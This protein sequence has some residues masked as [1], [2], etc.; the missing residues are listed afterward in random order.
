MTTL[1]LY[2][3]QNPD[4]P[5]RTLRLR[6]AADFTGDPVENFTQAEEIHGKPYFPSHPH[7]HFSVSHTGKL[8]ICAFSSA[9]VG[10]DVQEYL[11]NDTTERWKRLAKRWFSEGERHYLDEHDCEPAEF[12]RIWARK[13]AYVKFTGDGIGEGNFP[14]FDVTQPIPGCVMQDIVLPYPENHAAALVCAEEFVP[15]LR[16]LP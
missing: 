9:A 7:V 13:E 15:E 8:W 1:I 6:A 16:K 14:S 5:S 10:C 12:C 11:P 3:K 4:E 2:Y